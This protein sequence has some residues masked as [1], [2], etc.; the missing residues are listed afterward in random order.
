M[1]YYV[2]NAHDMGGY[3]KVLR[4]LPIP[5]RGYLFQWGIIKNQRTNAQNNAIHLYCAQLA[6]RFNDAGFLIH[7][8]F[9]GK[10]MEIDWNQDRV[11]SRLW[12]PTQ[13]KMLE[14]ESTTELETTEVTEVYDTLNRWMSTH[15]KIHVPFPDRF[16]R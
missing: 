9:F 1:Q 6:N 10:A 4:D 16:G 13:V 14:K 3:I 7:E 2:M 5:E 15:L 11:K 8:E 12:K